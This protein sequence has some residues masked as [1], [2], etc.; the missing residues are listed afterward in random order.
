VD[1]NAKKVRQPRHSVVG[2]LGLAGFAGMGP[3]DHSTCP[4]TLPHALP[5][6]RL[7]CP[8]LRLW[9]VIGATR[10]PSQGVTVWLS[11]NVNIINRWASPSK[12]LQPQKRTTA[13]TPNA[14]SQPTAQHKASPAPAPTPAREP[15]PCR[16]ESQRG[17]NT[18]RRHFEP[19]RPSNCHETTPQYLISLAT[20]LR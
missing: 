3:P 12:D 20:R 16:R 5:R 4:V 15:S 8:G 17:A 14:L 11:R 2:G 19:E 1:I 18:L 7:S 9:R 13:D 10:R 6:V